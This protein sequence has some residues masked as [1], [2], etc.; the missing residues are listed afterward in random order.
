MIRL[1]QTGG[2]HDGRV[3]EFHEGPVRMGR[4]PDSEIPLDAH[5]D[6]DVSGR[7]AEII[8]Q[9]SHWVVV[10]CGSRNGTFINGE[11]I[12]R[13]IVTPGDAIQ[14]GEDG[15]L[16]TVEEASVDLSY[17]KT[18]ATPSGIPVSAVD[19][20]PTPSAMPTP[21]PAVT[22]PPEHARWAPTPF[23]LP[24][25]A[26]GPLT[27]A[28]DAMAPAPLS[29]PSAAPVSPGWGVPEQPAQPAQPAQFPAPSPAGPAPQPAEPTLGDLTKGALSGGE[30]PI[31]LKVGV[32]VLAVLFCVASIVLLVAVF[33]RS[34]PPDPA[35]VAAANREALLQLVGRIGGQ[36]APFC[37]A[38]AVRS[39]LLA[40]SARCVLEIEQRQRGGA[41]VEVVQ[42][43]ERYRVSRLWRHPEFDSAS[44]T[45]DVGLVEVDRAL[46]LV[47]NLGSAGDEHLVALGYSAQG[48]VATPLLVESDGDQMRY[49]AILPSGAPLLDATGAVVGIHSAVPGWGD[50]AGQ[51]TAAGALESLLAGLPQ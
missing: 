11:R 32:G 6:L 12:G 14:L 3:V 1:R 7:H 42:G 51:A 17:A 25:A 31:A 19:P 39:S 27:P 28:S 24:D 47:V 16:F 8:V 34:S 18:Q 33:G 50:G 20:I 40:T 46:P 10:D 48:L 30:T 35:R 4:M 15:A 9:N 36:D 44:G 37:T 41:F 43:T 2:A 38:F 26:T 23:A 22:P 21:P 45:A 49:E 13:Q 5:K 29:V